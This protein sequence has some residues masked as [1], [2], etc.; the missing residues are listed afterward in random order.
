MQ[1]LNDI[2]NSHVITDIKPNCKMTEDDYQNFLKQ[3]IK[4][5]SDIISEE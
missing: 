2:I 1:I 4:A 3:I 5:N